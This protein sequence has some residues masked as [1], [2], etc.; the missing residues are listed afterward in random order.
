MDFETWMKS[1]KYLPAFMRDFHDQ[2][3]LFKRIEEIRQSDEKNGGHRTAELPDWVNAHIYVVDF[4]LWY[5]ARRG[6]TLQ[7][8]RK[9]LPFV[10]IYNDLEDFQK[11]QDEMFYKELDEMAK[12]KSSPV[13]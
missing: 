1:G 12:E 4:F 9:K 3:R 11:R 5:M 10:N 7:V 13:S 2:K 8:S 6:Y